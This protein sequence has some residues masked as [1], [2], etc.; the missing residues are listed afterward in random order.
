MFTEHHLVLNIDL[1]HSTTDVRQKETPHVFQETMECLKQGVW[2][3]KRIRFNYFQ[4]NL[5]TGNSLKRVL[6][7]WTNVEKRATHCSN[8]VG[9]FTSYLS[10]YLSVHL[11]ICLSIYLSICLSL[12]LSIYLYGSTALFPA[13]AAFSVSWFFTQS[14]EPLGWEISPSQG[15]YLHT[16]QHK[17]RIN[18]H[19]HSC[20]KWNSNSRSQRLSGRR[21]F[22][23]Q[24][25][26]PLWSA[27][28]MN[29]R[30]EYVIEV[31]FM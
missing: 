10:I 26:R 14:V 18:A 12:C 25:A 11:S 13:L 27:L 5:T 22:M 23:P 1:T 21:Q 30:S 6:E 28:V 31:T 16:G 3:G 4:Q 17:H 24:T 29:V 15:R 19:R 20:L 2:I 7:H 9:V 8:C